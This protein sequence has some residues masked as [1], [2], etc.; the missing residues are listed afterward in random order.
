MYRRY[1]RCTRRGARETQYLQQAAT[2]SL[3]YPDAA[4][5]KLNLTSGGDIMNLYRNSIASTPNAS[6]EK[7]K[8][9]GNQEC[10]CCNLVLARPVRAGLDY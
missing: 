9:N 5:V 7:Q 8:Q 3:N 6:A 10:C 1:R 2:K 4:A